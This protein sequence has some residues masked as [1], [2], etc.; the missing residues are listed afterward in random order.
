MFS[1]VNDGNFRTSNVLNM[2]LEKSAVEYVFSVFL[3]NRFE[4]K[5][6]L[7][8][9][10]LRNNKN[11]VLTIVLLAGSRLENFWIV[12]LMDI[13]PAKS[14]FEKGR[15]TGKQSDPLLHA[16]VSR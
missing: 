9:K 10:V 12:L 1:W 16:R 15:L 5:L 2:E 13:R 6:V 4:W 14:F 11:S 7:R 8:N 3:I